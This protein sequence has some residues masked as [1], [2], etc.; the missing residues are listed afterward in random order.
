MKL[1]IVATV[2]AAD[3]AN[4][5][6]DAEGGQTLGARA[7]PQLLVAKFSSFD[8]MDEILRRTGT[9]RGLSEFEDDCG[10]WPFGWRP[11]RNPL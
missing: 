2:L 9:E 7:V 8:F 3:E 10:C 11:I 1:G 4:W 6:C 5:I